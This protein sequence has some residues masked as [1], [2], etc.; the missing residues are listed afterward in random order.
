MCTMATVDSASPPA[1]RTQVRPGD[2]AGIRALAR[3]TG[4]FSAEEE[5]IATELVEESLARGEAAGYHYLFADGDGQIDGYVCY[6]PIPCTRESYDLYWIAV[7]PQTQGRGLGRR[8]VAATEERVAALGGS[9]I[10]VETSGRP[11]YG[12]T[13]AFYEACGYVVAARMADFYAPGDDKVVFLKV[14]S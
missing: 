10:Y 2:P 1:F 7:A 6:G 3:A 11:Q 14:L 9:R 4:F 5:Q 8:L 12:P 13:R